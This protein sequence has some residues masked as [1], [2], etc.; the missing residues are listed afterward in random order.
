MVLTIHL[1]EQVRR[2]GSVASN[3]MKRKGILLSEKSFLLSC[4]LC[5]H[6]SRLSTSQPLSG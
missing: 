5:G 3:K 4:K 6:R 2:Q 1:G